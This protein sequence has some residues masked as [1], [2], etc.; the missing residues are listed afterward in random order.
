MGEMCVH[1]VPS[2]TTHSAEDYVML[3]KDGILLDITHLS[4]LKYQSQFSRKSQNYLT[5]F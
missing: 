3:H 1:F 5:F 4:A 2:L